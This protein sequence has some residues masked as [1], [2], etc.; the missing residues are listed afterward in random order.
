M[1][2]W[3]PVEER[4][5]EDT[6]TVLANSNGS[7]RVG[8]LH[9]RIFC[10]EEMIVCSEISDKNGWLSNVTHWKSLPEPPKTDNRG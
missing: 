10:G 1:S 9:K 8:L 5:P 2:S 7:M 6:E 4:L 3:I